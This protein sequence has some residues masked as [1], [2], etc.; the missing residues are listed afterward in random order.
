V[1]WVV[2]ATAY[3][4]PP[5]G[6]GVRAR[7]LFGAVR[8]HDL[9]FLLAEDTPLSV[10]PPGAEVRRLPVRAA[11]PRRR[12]L[13]LRLPREGDV[14]FTDHYPAAATPT[15]ITLHDRGGGPVRRALVRRHLRRAAAVVAVSAAVRDAW[16]V[17]AAVVENGVDA[18]TGPLPPPGPHLLLA[19]PGLPHK[20]APVAR[21]A[22]R[23][24]GLELREVGRGARWLPHD[25]MMR[26][27]GGAA[28]VLCPSREEGF[29]M[30]ALEAMAAG[31]PVVASDLPAHREVL[32][33]VAFYADPRDAR[34]WREAVAAALA[35]GPERLARGLER[36]ARF[37]WEAA[38]RKLEAVVYPF[39]RT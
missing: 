37:T 8:G 27:L 24:L 33:D 4:D 6:A 1:R 28:A 5:G 38:A 10:V 20:G 3:G 7:G 14:L 34:A 15:V 16:G 31:R 18:P 17:R 35:C 13:S 21:E 11:R 12:W 26:E 23:A 9:L 2:N 29:G 25:G 30:V 32:G 39:A 36:A 22:A 19:D